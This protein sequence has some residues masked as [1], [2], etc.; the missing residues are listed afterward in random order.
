MTSEELFA[1][2]DAHS[3]D[4]ATLEHPAVFR[5]GEA[6]P[7]LEALPGGHT[8]NLFLRDQKGALWLVSALQSTIIDLKA[9]P[10][11]IGSGRLSFGKAELLEAVLG[12]TPGSVTAFALV[13]D[14]ERSVRFVLDK[15]LAAAD[16]VNFHPLR[17]TATTAVS[18][19]G[20]RRFLAALEIEPMVVDFKTLAH[21]ERWR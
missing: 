11:I 21:R 8:K 20:F 2:F 1:F 18:Q 15:A 13:N 9:L 5:V 3:V 6:S 10:A 16:P 4:H 19:A 17:N 14:R 12:V 7:E